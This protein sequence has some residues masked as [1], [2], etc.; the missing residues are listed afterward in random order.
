M[1]INGSLGAQLPHRHQFSF[2]LEQELSQKTH[3]LEAPLTPTT[4]LKSF[5]I[6]YGCKLP[7]YFLFLE[8]FWVVLHSRINIICLL[9][10]IFPELQRH[11]YNAKLIVRR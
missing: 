4:S 10:N 11:S 6:L 2:Q 8:F 9:L 7:E 3:F 5:R 1:L